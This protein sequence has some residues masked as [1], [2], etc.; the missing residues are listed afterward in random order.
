MGYLN[1]S[2]IGDVPPKPESPIGPFINDANWEVPKDKIL[3]IPHNPEVNDG[4]WG[5]IILPLKGAVKREWFNKHFYYCLPLNIGNQYGF[6]IQSL[7]D[8]DLYWKGGESAV[9]ISILNNDNM[10]KQ[11]LKNEFYHGVVT[12]QNPFGL[13]T[14]PGINIMT[15]QP[16]NRYIKGCAAMTGVVETDNIRRDFTFNFKVTVPNLKIEVRKGDWLGAFIPI[17][18]HFVDNFEV[19]LAAKHFPI[20]MVMKEKSE[21]L[22]LSHERTFEDKIN[23]PNM[24]GRR[25][26][27]GEH[28]DGISYP[29]HQKRLQ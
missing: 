10:G 6:A 22:R 5:E 15:I 13:K 29:D 1:S 28:T 14:P 19:D 16:P 17:P 26:F 23:N 4:Y 21:S 7:L 24:V 20:D 18:R 27:R 9:D 11:F 25:Y 8:F 3:V 12:V 2:D